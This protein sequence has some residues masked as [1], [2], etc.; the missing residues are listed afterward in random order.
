MYSAALVKWA[1][2]SLV[3]LTGRQMRK[4]ALISYPL[5]ELLIDGE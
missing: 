5:P 2:F 3:G 4:I 1:S